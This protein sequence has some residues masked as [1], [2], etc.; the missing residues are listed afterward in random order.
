MHG[1]FFT[2]TDTGVG[3]TWV[4]TMAAGHLRAQGVKVGAYKPAASGIE[5][6]RWPDV[7]LL[8]EAIGGGFPHERICPQRFDLPLAPPDA[9]RQENRE[10]DAGLLRS[11]AHW[12]NGQVDL[13]IVEGVG[14]LLCPLTETET[15][16]DLAA[17]LG[18]P[19]VIV[20]R[21]AL[22]TIN[23][24]LMTIDAARHRGLDISGVI[25]NQPQPPDPLD[26]SIHT[27]AQAI[28]RLG[29]VTIL[30]QVE[31][32][33]DDLLPTDATATIDWSQLAGDPR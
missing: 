16:A 1:L 28:T 13:L 5:N 14:G 32:G 22:G 4:A 31:H 10:I 12:W 3:K 9:A 17:E 26:H 19:V 18:W 23:H 8:H 30:G 2:G 21:N 11:G 25:L 29:Q 20:A 6:G 33:A 24:T 15:V 7:D 27:N